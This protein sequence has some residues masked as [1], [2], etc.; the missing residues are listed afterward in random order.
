VVGAKY[1]S[2]SNGSPTFLDVGVAYPSTKGFS[3]VIWQRHRASF[4]RPEMKYGNVT[5][6]VRGDVYSYNGRPQ[7]EA[8]SP[9]QVRIVG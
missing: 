4:G 9:S 1:A 6:C 3:V 8:V 5:I 2:A 7:I